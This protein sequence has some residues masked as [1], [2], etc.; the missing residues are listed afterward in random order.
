MKFQLDMTSRTKE[1]R[2]S[3][4]SFE[5]GFRRL[6]SFYEA[7]IGHFCRLFTLAHHTAPLSYI[8]FLKAIYAAFKSIWVS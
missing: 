7:K 1:N 3:K 6:S 5:A 4:F 2:L 8:H